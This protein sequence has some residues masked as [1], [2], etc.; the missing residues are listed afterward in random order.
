MYAVGKN[1]LEREYDH[2]DC[3]RCDELNQICIPMLTKENKSTAKCVCGDGFEMTEDGEC[4]EVELLTE[5]IIDNCPTDSQQSAK[6]CDKT[7]YHE[8]FVPKISR[9]G[10]ELP[11]A[12]FAI[13][14][15]LIHLGDPPKTVSYL[16]LLIQF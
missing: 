16:S 14:K 8:L 5:Y 7:V 4:I 6:L 13:T 11:L 3:I 12:D 15:T 10:Y 1:T 9:N 2:S